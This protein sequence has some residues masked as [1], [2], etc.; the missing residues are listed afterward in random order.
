MG[1][2]NI[3]STCVYDSTRS[4]TRYDILYDRDQRLRVTQKISITEINGNALHLLDLDTGEWSSVIFDKNSFEKLIPL[5]M[6]DT[7]GIGSR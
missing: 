4:N 1:I 2:K 3:Y 5:S 6:F 7:D